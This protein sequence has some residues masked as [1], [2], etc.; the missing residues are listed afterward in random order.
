MFVRT[1][2]SDRLVGP[3][4]RCVKSTFHS[5][6]IYSLQIYM[7]TGNKTGHGPQVKECVKM[8]AAPLEK[9]CDLI[10]G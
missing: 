1:G 7:C 10:I 2:K 6:V 9:Y 5:S 3:N 4:D 8:F